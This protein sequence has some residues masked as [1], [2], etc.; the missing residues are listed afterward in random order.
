M[1]NK[2]IDLSKYRID[3]A[4][5]ELAN[6]KLLY[7]NKSFL[8][9]NNRAYYSIFHTQRQIETA[10]ELIGLAEEYICNKM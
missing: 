9:A 4:R 1:D 7:K 10:E 6:A 8:A 2:A 3:R 5:E